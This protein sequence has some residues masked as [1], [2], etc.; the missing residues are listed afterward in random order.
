MAKYPNVKNN[1]GVEEWLPADKWSRRRVFQD[2]DRWKYD[3][4]QNTEK[5][6]SQWAALHAW[7]RAYSTAD[8][9]PVGATLKISEG[10][11]DGE[12]LCMGG[13]PPLSWDAM[14]DLLD[15][16]APSAVQDE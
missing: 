10:L 2:V 15:S 16:R 3:K 9:I 12:S 6:R 14:W 13:A 5:Y 11:P 8:S 4:A 1:P 7:H